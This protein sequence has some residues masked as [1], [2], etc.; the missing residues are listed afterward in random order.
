MNL[1]AK[2]GEH[3]Y[4]NAMKLKTGLISAVVFSF[5]ILLYV[6][7]LHYFK[8][9][10]TMV[11]IVTVLVCIPAAMALVRFIMFMRYKEGSLSVVEETEKLKGSIPVFYDSIITTSDKSYPVNVFFAAKNNLIGFSNYDNIDTAKLETHIKEIFNLNKF[12]EVNIK[13]FT[14]S[15]K[16]YDRLSS[17]G[18]AYD[19]ILET[20]LQILHL[21]GR[22]SL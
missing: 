1:K 17:L 13:V 11:G 4:I 10:K 16:F 8:E 12:H 9:Q 3:G 22:I 2:K 15:N 5:A 14:D 19:D 20:D 6:L 21:L 7:G 18:K